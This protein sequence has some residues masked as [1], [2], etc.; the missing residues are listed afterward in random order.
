ME[1]IDL[2]KVEYYKEQITKMAECDLY[3]KDSPELQID[4]LSNM[5]G[6]LLDSNKNGENDQ[7]IAFFTHIGRSL[8]ELIKYRTLNNLKNGKS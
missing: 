7:L 1:K 5:V 2:E 3:H 6:A 8:K 4:T